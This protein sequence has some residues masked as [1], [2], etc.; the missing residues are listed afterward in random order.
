MF[1]DFLQVSLM[2]DVFGWGD[3]SCGEGGINIVGPT[4]I[5]PLGEVED[6]EQ[7]A[8]SENC[9]LILTKTSGKVYKMSYSINAQ[10]GF[11]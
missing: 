2:Q 6:V 11:S 8:A 3:L 1:F 4:S 9:L 7:M 10:V 5:L